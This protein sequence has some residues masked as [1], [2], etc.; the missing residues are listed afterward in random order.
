MKQPELSVEQVAALGWDAN[1]NQYHTHIK[2]AV[3]DRSAASRVV[4]PTLPLFGDQTQDPNSIPLYTFDPVS[5][6]INSSAH[7]PS[8]RISREFVIDSD[9]FGDEGIGAFSAERAAEKVAAAEDALLILGATAEKRLGSLGVKVDEGAA[10]LKSQQGLFVDSK[11]IDGDSLYDTI[12]TGMAKL[13]DSYPNATYCVIVSP[14]LWA[15][16]VALLD[17]NGT[18]LR[19]IIEELLRP[20]G[21]RW[22]AAPVSSGG[23][24]NGGAGNGAQSTDNRLFRSSR[25]LD[26]RNGVIFVCRQD[27]SML[28]F[29]GVID[30]AVPCEAAVAY[31]SQNSSITLRVEERVKLRLN[32]PEAAVSF[33]VLEPQKG[34]QK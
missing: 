5:L 15:E 17:S 31:V 18:T 28:N 10:T 19:S 29:G 12:V 24:G 16:A 26:D 2:Q 30:I 11:A 7:V 33:K 1:T 9:G 4:R 3:H 20:S 14:A 8:V 32:D 34:L 27:G 25:A 6:Q 21:S 23:A 13:Q 22:D